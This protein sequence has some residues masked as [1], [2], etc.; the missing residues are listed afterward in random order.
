MY[1]FFLYKIDA[2]LPNLDVQQKREKI[3][4]KPIHSFLS[5]NWERF[6]QG[7]RLSWKACS[8]PT[9]GMWRLWVP[10]AKLR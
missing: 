4:I 3:S 5:E 10:A 7:K 8:Q 9:Q 6:I 1:I 2:K